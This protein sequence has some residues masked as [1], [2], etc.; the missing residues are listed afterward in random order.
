MVEPVLAKA[1]HLNQPED[2]F[3][4]FLCPRWDG[5]EV[6]FPKKFGQKKKGQKKEKQKR[7]RKNE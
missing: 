5:R 6:T 1:T 7:K 4:F 3:T 2:I